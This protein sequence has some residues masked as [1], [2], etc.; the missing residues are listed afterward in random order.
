MKKTIQPVLIALVA[1]VGPFHAAAE[2]FGPNH[3]H[4]YFQTLDRFAV[5]KS[6]HRRLELGTS[7]LQN[8]CFTTDEL[9][10]FIDYLRYDHNRVILAKRAY[11]LVTDPNNFK[12]IYQ[13]IDN[14]VDRRDLKSF[15]RNQNQGFRAHLLNFP[16]LVYPNAHNYT[17]PLGTQGFINDRLFTDLA[18]RVIDAHGQKYKTT[19]VESY[20]R[21]YEL[22]VAQF[23]KLLTLIDHESYRLQLALNFY[24]LLYD[25]GNVRFIEGVFRHQHN[26]NRFMSHIRTRTVHRGVAGP[27]GGR[28]HHGGAY[29]RDR[30][31]PGRNRMDQVIFSLN[32]EP[33]HSKR[34]VL[35]QTI[36]KSHGRFTTRQIAMMIRT[37]SFDS[38][39][40]E[41]IQ[42]AYPNVV[43]PENFYL[44]SNELTFSS[45][46]RRL[47]EFILNQ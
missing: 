34:V 9:I 5:L 24:H 39:K 12:L 44:L 21:D 20:A 42:F 46:R 15:I 29:H 6:E 2:C 3:Q 10:G 11:P 43:D 28:R 35:A 22:T 17:G 40:L 47:N 1:L 27:P 41:V 7:Y 33:F 25:Q 4:R 23:M 30:I 18:F 16:P 8:N 37:F 13:H 32:N 38:H 45:S 19:L 36:I 14:P 31:A 26:A